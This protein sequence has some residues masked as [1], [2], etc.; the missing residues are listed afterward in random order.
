MNEDIV[1][2]W[3]GLV[4]IVLALAVAIGIA[5]RQAVVR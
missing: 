2:P 5:S 4:L 1:M 3:W